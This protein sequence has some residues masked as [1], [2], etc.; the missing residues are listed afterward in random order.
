M[1][2]NQFIIRATDS[3][4]LF[5]EQKVSL[6]VENINDAPKRTQALDDFLE[7]QQPTAIEDLPRTID[8]ENTL[9]TGKLYFCIT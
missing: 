1:G 8:D 4:G 7:A 3:Y 5:A 2:I 9:F 6:E